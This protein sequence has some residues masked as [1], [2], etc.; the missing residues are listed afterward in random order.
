LAEDTVVAV[1]YLHT[2]IVQ[3]SLRLFDFNK[4]VVFIVRIGNFNDIIG[5]VGLDAFGIGFFII[6]VRCR[7]LVCAVA[8]LSLVQQTVAAAGAKLNAIAIHSGLVFEFLEQAGCEA[9][10]LEAL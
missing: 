2:S 3:V 7:A 4:A 9:A 6:V 8:E 10:V 5:R 1:A